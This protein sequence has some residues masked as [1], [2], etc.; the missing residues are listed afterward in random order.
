MA[1]NSSSSSNVSDFLPIKLDPT[2]Y[3]LW[4]A[5][6]LTLLRSRN[7]VSFVD[8][9]SKCPP[10]FLKDDEGI[11][12]DTVNPEFEA[13]IQQDNMVL[14]W[15][16]NSVH[17]T[18]LGAVI[19]K[20]SSHSAWTCLHERYDL[21][22]TGHLLQLRSELMNTHRGDSSISEFLS[23][24]S[25]L[26]DALSLSGA[27]V[28]DSDIAAIVLNN[29]GPACETTVASAQDRD[30]AISHSA[31]EA[32]LLTA[33]RKQRMHTV[34]SVDARPTAP[35]PAR[36]GGPG[37]LRGRGKG[38]RGV[39]ARSGMAHIPPHK[40]HSKE[41]ERPLPTSELLAQRFTKNLYVKPYNKSN[42][43]WTGKIAYADHSTYRWCA[44]ALD[45]EN[46]FP[47]SVNL[48]P[49]CLESSELKVEE[50]RLA[51]INTS[52]GDEG[53]ELEWNSLRSPAVSIA[54]NVLEDLVSSFKHVRN[55]MK[56]AQLKE[57]KPT[58]IARVGKVLFRRSALVN[59]E[60]MR[61]NLCTEILKQWRRS[62]YTNIPVSYKERIVNEVVPKIGA[63][64]EGEKN[65]Y[66]VKLSDS[67]RPDATLSCKC[68]VK[69]EHGKL[70]LY[71][72]EL[73]QL[74][75]MVVDI[76]CATK[77]LDLRL[78]LCT[79]R[80]VT[81]LTDDE[82]QSIR[83][84]IDSAIIDPDVKGG[85]RWPS[86]KDSSGDK[87]KV[88]GVW[89]LIANTYKNSSFRL[90][91][92]HADRFDF[93]TLS[94]EATWETSLMLKKVLSKLEEENTEAS[95]V[96]EILKEDMQLIWDNFL[97]CGRFLT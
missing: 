37:T 11:F 15:I 6:M 14:S 54:E 90:K 50:N 73:N 18:V 96:S 25:C 20:T 62:L 68:R 7:L 60:S 43:D 51:L 8:G 75:N 58:L 32:L 61:T 55:E 91:V 97:S 57:G 27:P 92:R 17:P 39:S 67:T 52:L 4:Q 45:E 36:G 93:R 19:R 31:S 72:I 95:S 89:H 34:F 35:A 42:V 70:Q 3:P 84:L 82:M 59:M 33:E 21:Q 64:F 41:Y 56:C 81:D 30:G 87:Y 16:K 49:I 1:S 66:Q 78:M 26:A 80:L 88:D 71:K 12:T 44:V 23:R 47:P 76:S 77:N 69:K 86:G 13:W 94:G 38:Y 46:Q 65:T 29:V 5:Q 28:S 83:D 40:R 2:N 85:L 10:A 74:R 48:K 79:K 24:V 63:D 22:P 9:T 53:G